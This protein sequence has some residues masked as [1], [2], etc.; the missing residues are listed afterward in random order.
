MAAT[1][2]LGAVSAYAAA[3]AGG[4]TGTKEQFETE[5]ANLPDKASKEYV[6]NEID[7]HIQ[8]LITVLSII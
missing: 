5:L 1:N 2:D 6:G 3:V 4:Y 8:N 7:G